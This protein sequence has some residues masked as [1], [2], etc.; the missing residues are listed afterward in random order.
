MATLNLGKKI[1]NYAIGKSGIRG[2]EADALLIKTRDHD[3]HRSVIRRRTTCIDLLYIDEKRAE[4][5][6]RDCIKGEKEVSMLFMM[7]ISCNR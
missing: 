1:V 5:P 6:T 7:K 4:I 2:E 3:R